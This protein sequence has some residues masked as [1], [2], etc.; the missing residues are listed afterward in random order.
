MHSGTA[1]SP[2]PGRTTPTR[3]SF[4]KSSSRRPAHEARI[5]RLVDG[6][7]VVPLIDADGETLVLDRARCS[8]ADVLAD[9][10]RLTP[11]EVRGVAVATGRALARCHAQE[12]VHGDVK[13][14][15]LLL[16]GEGDLW[17]AD[18]DTA[19]RIDDPRVGHSPGR[20]AGP[21]LTIADD[22]RALVATALE[23]SIGHPVDLGAAWSALQLSALGCPADLAAELA[24]VLRRP[25]SALTVAER[26]DRAD[27]VL[28]RAG[29]PS[30]A[31]RTPTVPFSLLDWV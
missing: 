31:D 11:A 15:N 6:P 25:S 20:D 14:A 24:L 18:F 17:L 28:P 8:V 5:L 10:G 26:L 21:Y 9:R 12:I 23:C 27:A 22:V 19:G 29:A 13:P 1:S 4:T 16:S 2:S 7:G 3:P 30:R